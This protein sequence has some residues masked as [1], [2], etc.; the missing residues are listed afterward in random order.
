M[1]EAVVKVYMRIFG[2][3]LKVIT[4]IVVRLW[5]VKALNHFNEIQ[6]QE[7]KKTDPRTR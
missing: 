4:R 7:E 3:E 6:I 5:I 2:I 1:E